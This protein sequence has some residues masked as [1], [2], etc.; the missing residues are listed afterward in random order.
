MT[1]DLAAVNK[2]IRK[3]LL[4]LDFVLLKKYNYCRCFCRGIGGL[5]NEH[6][7]SVSWFT[8]YH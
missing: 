1:L 4:S 6:L 8:K 3:L 5:E 2:F 7:N